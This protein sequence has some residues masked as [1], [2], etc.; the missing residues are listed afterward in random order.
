MSKDLSADGLRGIAALTVV[1]CH[2]LVSFSPAGYKYLYPGT[3]SANAKWTLLDSIISIPSISVLWSGHFAVCV[4]FVLSGYVLT[5]KYIESGDLKLLKLSA[6]RRYVRLCVPVFG[7]VM[8]SYVLFSAGFKYSQSAGD[9]SGSSWLTSFWDFTPSFYSAL[10]EGIYGGI[11]DGISIYTPPLWTMKIEFIGS[12]L[13]FAYAALALRGWHAAAGFV[14]LTI[15]LIFFAPS[16]WI[17]YVGFIA[18]SYIGAM[19]LT[20]N[21]TLIYGVL[22]LGVVLGGFDLSPFY[23]W[24]NIISMEVGSRKT[25]FCM[26]GGICV[27]YA[28]RAGALRSLWESHPAQFLGKISYSLYLVHFPILLTFSSWFY[29]RLAHSS[30]NPYLSMALN[31]FVSCLIFLAVAVVFTKTFD[32][33]GILLSKKLFPG[34]VNTGLSK[35][36]AQQS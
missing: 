27:V 36:V 4:F 26:M 35:T 16:E 15:A 24:T 5:K 28:V 20:K 29:I 21:K 2:F 12:M 8:L 25:L 32:R 11:F 18:G 9:I 6:A 14:T 13:V 17:Y 34:N 1:I 30:I 23:D 22:V 19:N 7:S 3:A 33:G 10:K 31:F